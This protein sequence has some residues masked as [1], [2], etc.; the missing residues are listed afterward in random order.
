MAMQ[1]TLFFYKIVF[2][3]GAAYAVKVQSEFA[4][5]VLYSFKRESPTTPSPTST[6]TSTVLIFE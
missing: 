1:N 4:D 5:D 2:L 6:T 3:F